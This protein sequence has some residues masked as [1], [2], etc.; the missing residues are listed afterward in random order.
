MKNLMA[1]WSGRRLAWKRLAN[2]LHSLLSKWERAHHLY[3]LKSRL[4]RLDH[5]AKRI[6]F[7]DP[8]DYERHTGIV[9]EMI[10]VRAAINRAK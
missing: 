7:D 2:L 8:G 6:K 10:K 9:I 5:R 3:C 1:L 4:S